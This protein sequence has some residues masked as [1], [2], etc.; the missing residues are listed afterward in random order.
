[1]TTSK[2]KYEVRCPYCGRKS[3][4]HKYIGEHLGDYCVQYQ[5]VYTCIDCE[6]VFKETVEEA[7]VRE[8]GVKLLEG[9]DVAEV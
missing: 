3:M 8:A 4:K 7:N 2:P 6:M 5:F 1:M 9:G